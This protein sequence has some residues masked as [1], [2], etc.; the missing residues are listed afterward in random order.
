MYNKD[1]ERDG[2]ASYPDL[3]TSEQSPEESV[4]SCQVAGKEEVT[5]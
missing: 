2:Q 1:I 3:T 5:C 4:K